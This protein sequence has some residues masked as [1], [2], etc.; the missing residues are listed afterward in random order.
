[1]GEVQLR[2]GRS[3]RLTSTRPGAGAAGRGGYG[4]ATGRERRSA[5]A[6][7]VGASVALMARR[8]GSAR[9]TLAWSGV[10]KA[11]GEDSLRRRRVAETIGQ[12]RLLEA[13]CLQCKKTGRAERESGMMLGVSELGNN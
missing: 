7:R 11:V 10:A 8:A 6:R 2:R 9:A 12:R 3:A 13:G 5:G 1:M 4:E